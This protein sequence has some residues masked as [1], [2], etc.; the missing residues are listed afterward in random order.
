VSQIINI[1][2]DKM[3]ENAEKSG[4]NKQQLFDLFR[5]DEG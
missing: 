2:M 4:V 3:R 1:T 5:P